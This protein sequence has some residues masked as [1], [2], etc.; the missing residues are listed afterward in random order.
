MTL[1]RALAAERLG[2]FARYPMPTYI[3]RLIA[4]YGGD[5]VTFSEAEAA[6]LADLRLILTPA[7]VPAAWPT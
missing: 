6:F 3:G 1:D 4:A 5:G 7:P 2:T